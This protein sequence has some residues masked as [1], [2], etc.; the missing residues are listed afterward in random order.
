MIKRIGFELGVI[1]FVSAV[2]SVAFNG[3]RS[4]GMPWWPKQNLT[5][6]VESTVDAQQIFA[7][8][9]LDKFQKDNVVFIDVRPEDEYRQSHIPGAK[10]YR[11]ETIDDWIDGFF[12]QV[13]QD[14]EIIV[15]G[16]GIES[17]APKT[18]AEQLNFAGFE[19][20]YYMINGFSRWKEVGGKLSNEG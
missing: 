13:A 7:D 2:L 12:S 17:D 1:I 9:A 15:Y 18:L 11:P 5:A 8:I 19:N 6:S 16:D 10:N 4:D 14:K 20:V 3:V